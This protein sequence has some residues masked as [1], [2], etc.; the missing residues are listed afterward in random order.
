MLMF[1]LNREK[2]VEQ[3]VRVTA[4]RIKRKKETVMNKSFFTEEQVEAMRRAAE[5]A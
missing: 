1:L 3:R 5:A 2:V 4:A